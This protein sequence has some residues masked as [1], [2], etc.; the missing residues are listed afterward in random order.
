MDIHEVL[1]KLYFTVIS[2][3]STCCFVGVKY[4]SWQLQNNTGMLGWSK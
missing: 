4:G 2:L 3:H 1:F